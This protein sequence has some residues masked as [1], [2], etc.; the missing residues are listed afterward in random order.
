L[1]NTPGDW[2][3]S[4]LVFAYLTGW[5]VGAILALKRSDVD[6]EA[7]TA[8][9]RAESNK[10]RRDALISLHPMI[11]GHLKTLTGFSDRMF[12]WPQSRSVLFRTFGKLQLAAKVKPATKPR[13]GFHDIR[14]G[15]ATMNADRLTADVL[16]ET[17]QHQSYATTKLYINLARQLKPSALKVFAPELPAVEAISGRSG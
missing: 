12:P 4:F 17:M 14:R 10:G 16:Q 6:L 1:P 2:W 9:S 3:R 8:L 13:Y 7:G 15:F 5:R 11:V